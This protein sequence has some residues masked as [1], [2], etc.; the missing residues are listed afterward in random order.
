MNASLAPESEVVANCDHPV[1]MFQLSLETPHSGR[2][3]EPVAN[4]DRFPK[5]TSTKRSGSRPGG[6]RVPSVP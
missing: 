2:C 3:A 6:K 4:C 5:N 1:F